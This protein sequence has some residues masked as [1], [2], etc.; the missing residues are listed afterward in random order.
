ML[1][2]LLVSGGLITSRIVTGTKTL[3][4]VVLLAF[5]VISTIVLPRIPAVSASSSAE[6]WHGTVKIEGNGSGAS[7]VGHGPLLYNETW[8]WSGTFDIAIPDFSA[9][10]YGAFWAGYAT[11]SGTY[12]LTGSGKYNYS[13]TGPTG[14]TTGQSG[15]VSC[16]G[17]GPLMHGFNVSV[18]YR[19]IAGIEFFFNI[20]V[21]YAGTCFYSP[22]IDGTISSQ[23]ITFG[24]N[25][26][27]EI[28]GVILQSGATT[29]GPGVSVTMEGASASCTQSTLT[30][31]YPVGTVSVTRSGSGTTVPATN[32]MQLNVGD[33]VSTGNDGR[34]LISD[35]ANH[36]SFEVDSDSEFT[37]NPPTSSASAVSSLLKGALHIIDNFLKGCGDEVVT[38]NAVVAV[39]ATEFAVRV[40]PDNST[41]VVAINDTV[42]VR[43]I[44]SGANITLSAGQQVTVNDTGGPMTQAA[45]QAAVT[46]F[47]PT[48]AIEWWLTALSNSST[49]T[50]SS[51]SSSSSRTISD[52]STTSSPNPIPEFPF[53]LLVVSVFV[54]LIAVSYIA[55]RKQHSGG[56][57]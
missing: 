2:R 32:G 6:E 19:G 9:S 41:N 24:A 45:L 50:S 4:I 11:G 13:Q 20:T 44:A 37:V 48:A 33:I 8:S 26:G 28:L 56:L 34:A 51:S 30:I 23:N 25:G 40:Y 14:Q 54:L 21:P 27:A 46:M 3:A 36:Y 18:E 53:R 43:D 47:A 10:G 52:S 15:A 55:L 1:R 39:R 16:S 7:Y 38:P 5:S 31:G 22:P 29:T 57:L 42:S 49:T 17:E 35:S 12:R